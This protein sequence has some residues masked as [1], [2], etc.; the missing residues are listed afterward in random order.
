[1]EEVWDI[2]DE[3][4]NKTGRIMKKGL[5]P[6]GFYHQGADVWIINSGN[7]ILIQKR[8]PQKR[9]SPN[10][11][12]MTGGSV[13]RGETS[14]Q[15]IQRET[16]EELGISLNMK[17]I[18]LVKQYKTGTVWLD[19]YLIKQDIDL[20]D[21]IMQEEEVCEVKW[22]TYKEIEELFAHNQFME[23]R[24]EYIKDIIKDFIGE[25]I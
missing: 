5:L 21:I 6:E 7:K 18:K 9:N 24:W 2:L 15:T 13:I 11:W 20:K 10:V 3:K 4:G 8:S 1:M 16:K 23:N 19:T 12:A 14:L 17:D 25:N 22:A